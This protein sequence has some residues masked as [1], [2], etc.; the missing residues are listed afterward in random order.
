MIFLKG[1][2]QTGP[3]VPRE[4]GKGLGRQEESTYVK[5]NQVVHLVQVV[6]ESSPSCPPPGKFHGSLFWPT[7]VMRGYSV[8]VYFH[9]IGVCLYQRPGPQPY[10]T[11]PYLPKPL[12]GS[13]EANGK[14][15]RGS[16]SSIR[17]RHMPLWA[18]INDTTWHSCA[19]SAKDVLDFMLNG[20]LDSI[21]IGLKLSGV[22]VEVEVHY[23]Y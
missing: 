20:V 3:G 2:I 8:F 11:P 18:D 17:S 23:C 1:G 16:P 12:K 19:H 13:T 6:L 9:G 22:T 5:T 10:P 15:L 21:E 14:I 4:G 7:Q